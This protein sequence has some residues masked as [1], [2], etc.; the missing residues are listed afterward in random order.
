VAFSQWG[1]GAK[2]YE[3]YDLI[4]DP[5]EFTNQANNPEYSTI[6]KKMKHLLLKSRVQAGYESYKEKEQ[7]GKKTK[8][9][10]ST[11]H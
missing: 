4:K 9:F 7:E 3:L 5:G 6:V 1:Y 11:K 10:K 8:K 2:G